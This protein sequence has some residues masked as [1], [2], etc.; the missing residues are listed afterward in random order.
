MDFSGKSAIVVG[1]AGG[2]GMDLCSRLLQ[3][4]ISVSEGTDS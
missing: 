2:I 3:Q 4:N 1:G